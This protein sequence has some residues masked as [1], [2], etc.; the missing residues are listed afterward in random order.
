MRKIVLIVSLT[1]SVGLSSNAHA[2]GWHICNH[3]PEELNVAIAYKDTQEQW[4]SKGWHN[5]RA[6]GGCTMVMDENRTEYTNVYYHAQNTSGV[7][8]IG[9]PTRFCVS[10]GVFTY[11]QLPNCT[12]KAGFHLTVIENAGK[13]TTNIRG[14]VDGRTCID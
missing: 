13:Y 9:G 4:I 10:S 5:L 1:V 12:S 11:R 3:T 6:C 7:E 2:E 14:S 8:R